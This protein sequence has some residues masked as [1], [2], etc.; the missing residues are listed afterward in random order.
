M[1]VSGVQ[2]ALDILARV[3]LQP[4]DSV[5]MEDPGYFGAVTAFR[6]AGAE[7]VPVPIDEQ[8]ICVN[9]GKRHAPRAKGVYVTPA[10]Q[11]PLGVM[12]SLERRL[13][14]LSWAQKSGAFVIEDD[15]DGEC[16]LEGHRVSALQTL[17]P[18]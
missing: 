3:L 10:H 6:N 7:V 12:M 18:K 8:G 9:V 4:G 16:R 2:Q 14:V 11:F 15:Y 1:I 17:R 5:W 13:K